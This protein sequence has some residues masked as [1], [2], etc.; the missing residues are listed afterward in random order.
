MRTQG[1][2]HPGQGLACLQGELSQ[3][4]LYAFLNELVPRLE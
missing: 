2:Q 4:V 1:P 3:A